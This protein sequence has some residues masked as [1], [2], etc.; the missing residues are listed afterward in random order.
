MEF[1]IFAFPFEQIGKCLRVL[2]LSGTVGNIIAIVLYILASMIPFG[3]YVCMR[4]REKEKKIDLILPLLSWFLFEMLYFMVNPG[5]M[6]E[7]IAGAGMGLWGGTFYS[8]LIGYLIL[9]VII[10]M[11]K[12]MVSL[13]KSLR[14]ILYSV[15]IL[16]M[17]SV[18]AEIVLNLP[19]AIEKVK[20]TNTAV[21]DPFSV[22]SGPGLFI[23]YVFLTLKSLI[24]ALPN[25]L[26]A[27]IVFFCVQALNVL[28]EESYCEK[29]VVLV[30]KVASLCKKSLVLVV[31]TSM[32]FNIM[33]LFFS[34]QLYQINLEIN[35][36]IF[37]VLFLL[38]IH[39]MASYIEENQKLKED[40][41]LFI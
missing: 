30:K 12:D 41:E 15:M 19:A 9:R 40:N 33:Q 32:G 16:L 39:M 34:S 21:G 17:W 20:M 26:C 3:I 11:K 24:A 14:I 13:Q 7:V 36:P 35:I 37:A 29:A 38:T 31:V 28:L 1:D 5:L 27:V 25:G 6:P 18:V 8:I 2:S 10:G 22:Y 4:I 23:T